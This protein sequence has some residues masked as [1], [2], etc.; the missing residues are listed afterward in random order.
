VHS[1][2][3]LYITPDSHYAFTSSTDNDICAWDL[4]NGKLITRLKQAGDGMRLSPD[5]RCVLSRFK[6]QIFF[7]DLGNLSCIRAL[8]LPQDAGEGLT[9]SADNRFLFTVSGERTLQ[10]WDVERMML[11]RSWLA[12]DTTVNK[13]FLTPDGR[14][15]VTA[16]WDMTIK[17]WELDWEYTFPNS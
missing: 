3:S 2:H 17:L 11:L 13:H 10:A 8:D 12:H 16:S 5:K 7:W 4:V 14:Y 1:P 15:M 6:Q 9:F